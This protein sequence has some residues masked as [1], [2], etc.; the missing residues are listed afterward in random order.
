MSQQQAVLVGEM[1][2]M[3]ANGSAY[4]DHDLDAP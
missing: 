2:S 4:A 1:T 3:T